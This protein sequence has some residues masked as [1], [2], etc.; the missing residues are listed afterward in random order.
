MVELLSTCPVNWGMAPADAMK[1][2]DE[3]MTL[4]FKPG[5]YK[6]IDHD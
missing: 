1:W 3:K 5:V 2:I 6:D 4:T